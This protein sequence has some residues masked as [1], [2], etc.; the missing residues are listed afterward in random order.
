MKTR[1]NKKGQAT[2]ETATNEARVI[3]GVTKM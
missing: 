1:G 2:Q 3:D